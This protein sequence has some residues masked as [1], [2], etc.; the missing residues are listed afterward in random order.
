VLADAHVRETGGDHVTGQGQQ[1]LRTVVAHRDRAD[2]EGNGSDICVLRD[3]RRE[4]VEQSVN[5][6]VV[7]LVPDRTL[8][9]ATN[10]PEC[11]STGPQYVQKRRLPG[12]R[13][14]PGAPWCG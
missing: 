12:D 6:I 2:G 10:H 1:M 8:A 14:R 7:R 3:L 13:N 11:R 5:V 4:E 9:A